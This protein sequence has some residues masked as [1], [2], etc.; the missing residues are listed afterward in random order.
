TTAPVMSTSTVTLATT[1]A[2]IAWTTDEDADSVVWYA[3]TTPVMDALLI[4]AEEDYATSTTHDIL[5][6]DLTAS[7]TYFFVPFSTD[8]AGNTATG[9]ES[10]FFIQPVE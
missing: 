3:T 6:A 7:T 5:L 2:T 8:V 10:S 9:T 1:S 4:F